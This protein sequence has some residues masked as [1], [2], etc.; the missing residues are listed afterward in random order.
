MVTMAAPLSSPRR[1]DTAREA[2]R[3]VEREKP[4]RRLEVPISE[5]CGDALIEAFARV[6]AA[7]YGSR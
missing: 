4:T 2:L 6:A 7:Y 1:D 5:W 3:N